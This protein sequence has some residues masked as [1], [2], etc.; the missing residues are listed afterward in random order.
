VYGVVA[1]LLS[2][3]IGLLFMK[4]PLVFVIIVALLV[5]IPYVVQRILMRLKTPP[6]AARIPR[7]SLVTPVLTAIVGVIAWLV[8]MLVGPLLVGFWTGVTSAIGIWG[9][10]IAALIAFIGVG[11]TII[12][13]T[14]Q[15]PISYLIGL[16][17]FAVVVMFLTGQGAT[18]DNVPSPQ[19][20]QQQID[21]ACKVSP[22][23]F[24]AECG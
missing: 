5:L 21:E 16:A 20:N 17:C 3:F 6:A 23:L 9:V 10:V 18:I 14:S 7:Q 24:P 19:H 4:S 1:G 13:A 8:G 12:A 2:A 15:K 22:E 11:G